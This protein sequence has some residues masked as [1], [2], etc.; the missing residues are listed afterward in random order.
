MLQRLDDLEKCREKERLET[1][2]MSAKLE[3]EAKR[4]R[5][6][7]SEF[8]L[9]RTQRMFASS[10][11]AQNSKSHSNSPKADKTKFPSPCMHE[12]EEECEKNQRYIALCSK[13][14]IPGDGIYYSMVYPKA[15]MKI[16]SPK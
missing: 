16:V 9:K 11:T 1:A 6:L 8:Y 3:L 2:T 15:K 4:I 13:T 12:V 7:E 10:V 14:S 5:D